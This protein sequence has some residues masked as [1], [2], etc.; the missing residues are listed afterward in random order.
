M[1]GSLLQAA[2]KSDFLFVICCNFKN[3]EISREEVAVDR[4][5]VTYSSTLQE[6]T[7]YRTMCRRQRGR[8]KASANPTSNVFRVKVGSPYRRRR[9]SREGGARPRALR[10]EIELKLDV[11]KFP[12]ISS[13][14]KRRSRAASRISRLWS[15]AVFVGH[16]P[17]SI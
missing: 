6:I 10:S 13:C 17:S 12:T 5:D 11:R 16:M 2:E 3:V 1:T 7:Q 8:T 9:W 14:P 15:H 4:R